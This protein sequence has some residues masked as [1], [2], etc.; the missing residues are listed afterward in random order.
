MATAVA[1]NATS[2]IVNGLGLGINPGLLAE[3]STFQNQ[4][5]VQTVGNI[6]VNA[7]ISGNAY[8]NVI[9]ALNSLGNG[10]SKARWLLDYY[11]D[12]ETPVCSGSIFSYA[13]SVSTSS[14][15]SAISVQ[16]QLPFSNGLSGFANVFQRAYGYSQQIFD[17]VS[18]INILKNTTYNQSGVGYTGPVDLVTGGI[19][20]YGNVLAGVV[21]GWGTMYDI[22]NI[23]QVNDPYVFGQN[24][25]NQGLGY[26]NALSDQLAATGLDITNL[27]D[28]SPTIT[29]TTQEETSVT[30]STFV[31]EVEIP[32]LTETTTTVAVTGNSPTVILNIYANVTGSNLQTISNATAISTTPA[33]NANITSLSDYLNLSKIV[34][35]STLSELTGLGI[36]TFDDFSTYL[37]KKVGQGRFKNWTDLSTFL[38][39]LET[40][41]LTNLPTGTN[42]SV[43]YSSSV[44]T[45]NSQY[46]TGSGALGNPVMIDYLGACSGN[47]YKNVFANLNSSYS[48]ISSTVEI[49][50]NNL[51]QAVI[52]YG[53]A[54][55]AFESDFSSNT[56]M[57]LLEPD[58]NMITSNVTL[59]NTAMNSIS[60]SSAYFYSN[61]AYYSAIGRMSLEVSNLHKADI[62]SFG[63]TTP[64]GL[65]G[66]AESIGPLASDKTETETY[67]FFANVITD[68]L[69]GDTIRAVVAET[70]NNRILNSAG[71]NTYNDP[72]P[73]SA[74]YQSQTQNIPLSTYISRNK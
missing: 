43:L 46:G 20:T 29:T 3:I 1:L 8:S 28:R 40:P 61:L 27:T 5:T 69:A 47:P 31:G 49:A 62:Y 70:I 50:L 60:N 48:T 65:L 42:A 30:I 59:V 16:A 66:F 35:G 38:T 7:N 53:T 45:L 4:G 44:T 14:F 51:D 13:N 58:I 55:A 23:S 41:I 36:T 33:N 37:S 26:V 67:Q 71:I 2:S 34:S 6:F 10:V 64:T 25:L 18:S 73:R 54:Y 74:V 72:E 68:D 12:G 15:S 57:G 24:L 32:T 39:S 17:T 21:S 56:P 22:N 19:G 63:A 9:S 52:D 11:P